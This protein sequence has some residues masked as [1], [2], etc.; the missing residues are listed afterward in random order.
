[1][2]KGIKRA[3]AF[4]QAHHRPMTNAELLGSAGD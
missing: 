2:V 4:V 1:M 3:A